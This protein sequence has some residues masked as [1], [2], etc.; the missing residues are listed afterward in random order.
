MLLQKQVVLARRN[1]IPELAVIAKAHVPHQ[2]ESRK[3]VCKTQYSDNQRKKGKLA[4][5]EK[6]THL[7]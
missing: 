7:Y 2:P 4:K 1:K 6:M 3:Y 5:R